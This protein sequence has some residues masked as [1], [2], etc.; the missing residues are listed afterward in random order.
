[1]KGKVKFFN[2]SKR[3]GFV[4]GEDGK[5]YFMHLSQITDQTALKEQDEV[6]FEPSQGD[7][8]LVALNVKKL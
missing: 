1:M 7:R 3:F 4:S 5:D 6:E 8:G 2:M